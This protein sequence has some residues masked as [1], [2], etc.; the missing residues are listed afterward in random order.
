MTLVFHRASD[1]PQTHA[2]VIGV[3]RFPYLNGTSDKLMKE[4]RLVAGVTSPPNNAHAM[5]E[6]LVKA[7]DRLVPPLGSIELLI[8]ETD[9]TVAQ[10]PRGP[11]SPATRE[12]DDVDAATGDNVEA[13][14][15]AWLARCESDANNLAFF[16]GSSHGMQSQEHILLLEDAGERAND[17]WRNML[18]LNHLHRNLYKKAHKRSLL[19]ADCCRNLLEAGITS[20]DNFSGRRIGEISVEDYA[21][22]RNEPDRFVYMLR[23]TP[24]GVVAKATRDGLGYFTASLLKCLEGGAGQPK[25][26]YGWCISPG[27]LRG[28]VEAAGRYGLG[29]PDSDIRP[30]DDDSSWDD[31]PIL[32]LEAMPRFPVRVREAELLDFGR[33]TLRLAQQEAAFAEER[34]PC[35]ANVTALHAWVPPNFATY[36][37]TGEIVEIDAAVRLE[38]V[39]VPV[40]SEGHD[41]PLRRI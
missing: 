28:W 31:R 21:K 20:L 23:A 37:A 17:Q 14:L 24:P 32:Q 29:I 27:R 22:A 38:T 1:A 2:I 5:A 39:A 36:E 19:F 3:G 25:P 15:E 41:V 12:N 9:G 8:S 18:S 30:I 10:F 13:A 33:A 6:W 35:F 40:F 16:F 11:H 4:L 34:R 26:H 7:A